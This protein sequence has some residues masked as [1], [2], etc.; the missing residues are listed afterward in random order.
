[1]REIITLHCGI[2]NCNTHYEYKFNEE[3]ILAI[4]SQWRNEES[5]EGD[6]AGLLPER[7]IIGGEYELLINIPLKIDLNDFFWVTYF[8]P[9]TEH[10]GLESEVGIKKKSI[11][12]IT[13]HYARIE[14]KVIN[15][16]EINA[17]NN[18]K[19]ETNI[20]TAVLNSEIE[21]QYVSVENFMNFSMIMANYESDCG[22]TYII[23]KRNGESRIVAENHWDFHRDTWQLINEK[24]DKEQETKYGIQHGV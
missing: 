18:I 13:K 8:E 16:K 19:E 15:T 1:M 21:S 24:I 17:H 22:W 7:P 14:V 3:N 10:E 9:Y 6:W 20:R 11:I 4:C 23:E 12:E 2:E 5:K